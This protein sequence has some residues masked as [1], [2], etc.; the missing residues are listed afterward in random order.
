MIQVLNS[1]TSAS[2]N[3]QTRGDAEIILLSIENS[4]F[5]SRMFY[6]EEILGQ[7]NLIQKKHQELSIDLGR[8][9][10]HGCDQNFLYPKQG[11]VGV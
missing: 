3:L 5:M 6:W 11:Q 4:S 7:I 8:G 9:N 2:E 10:S 1:F